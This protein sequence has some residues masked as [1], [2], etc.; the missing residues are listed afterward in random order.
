MIL[1]KVILVITLFLIF[2]ILFYPKNSNEKYIKIAENIRK[3]ISEKY[4]GQ[5]FPQCKS[6]LNSPSY[7]LLADA[8]IV[9]KTTE[10]LSATPFF[11]YE[12]F[13]EDFITNGWVFVNLDITD[14]SR[15]NKNSP[16]FIVC[17]TQQAYNIL[18]EKFPSKTVIYTGF[19]SFDKYDDS[20][21]KD[22]SKFIHI[23]GKS[24][25]KGTETLLKTWIKHPEWPELIIVTREHPEL[26]CKKIITSLKEGPKNIKFIFKFLSEEN[27]DKLSNRIG[28]HICP[29]ETEGFG[30][31]LHEA[32]A[33]SSVVLYT[34]A[35]PMNETFI[36]GYN[37]ISIECKFSELTNDIC[38][39][40]KIT[41]EGLEKSIKQ[42]LEMS[43]E[44]RAKIGKLAR[45]S[46]LEE[47]QKFETNLSTAIL[48][49]NR[50]PKI[51]HHVWISKEDNYKNVDIPKKY[52][53]YIESWKIHNADFTFM[54]WSGEKI[55]NLIKNNFPEFLNFYKNLKLISK[56]DFARFAISYIYGGLYSDVDYMC[57]NNVDNLIKGDSYFIFEP[58]THFKKVNNKLITNAI[59]AVHPKSNIAY[60]FLIYMLNQNS[61]DVLKDTGPVGLYKYLKTCPYKVL[62]GKTCD[63]ISSDDN[64]YTP[65]CNGEYNNYAT[66][67]W[68]DGSGW[69]NDYNTIEID[70]LPFKVIKNPIDN[71]SLRIEKSDINIDIDVNYNKYLSEVLEDPIEAI[72]IAHALKNKNSPDIVYFT[73]KD[74]NIC[75]FVENTALINAI[76]NIK[77][78]YDKKWNN[79]LDG[80]N[81]IWEINKSTNKNLPDLISDLPEKRNIFEISKNLKPNHSIIDVYSNNG[82]LAI[83][84]AKALSNY[85]RHD[86]TVYAIDPSKNKCDF[87]R[88]IAKYNDISNIVILQ[89]TLDNGNTIDNL[90]EKNILGPIGLYIKTQELQTL[91]GSENLI[92]K[93][94]PIIYEQKTE[95]S[96]DNSSYLLNI[97]NS[98]KITDF[99]PNKK[100][101]FQSING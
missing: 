37:G 58:I 96:K 61:G 85:G 31:Y 30:H 76:P 24:P 62:Y 25:L 10:N 21:E 9:C 40:Y 98:Y 55:L 6:I 7:G 50:I 53:K 20:V 68:S 54:Y 66:T 89:L 44:E 35:P 75:N 18:S 2:I 87:M 95:K 60:N 16:Q 70:N 45:V 59:F 93:Y 19:T 41:E 72:F 12:D 73:N 79:F 27:L 48:G 32:K 1:W 38:P 36:D 100:I 91:K 49:H 22:Y 5:T 26:L 42:V 77:I 52:E 17:K 33:L 64:G 65:E 11:Y 101:I 82:H 78:S 63:L 92:R 88:R 90:L 57:R 74:I 99:I 67:V 15:F 29:S 28:I 71:S 81:V 46:F 13:P 43:I 4:Y 56:C 3:T 94:K 80:S 39:I 8:S 34:D 84:L 69:G 47:K 23:A 14:F 51:I 97:D 86:I 83:P